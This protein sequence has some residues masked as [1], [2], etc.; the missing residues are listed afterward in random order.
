LFHD[1]EKS[2]N[3]GKTTKPFPTEYNIEGRDT[4]LLVEQIGLRNG[5]RKKKSQIDLVTVAGTRPEIIKLAELVPLLNRR[6]NHALLYT[7]QHFSENMKDIFF[8]ELHMAPDYE[9]RS[10]TSDIGSLKD[11]LVKCLGELRPRYVIVYGDTNSSMAAALAAEQIGSNLIHIEAGVR[12]FDLAVPEESIRIYI[13]SKA[14]YLFSPSQF[15]STV[16]AY[17][18]VRGQVH[19]TGNLIVD[20]CKKLYEVAMTKYNYINSGNG[21]GGRKRGPIEAENK[22]GKE[23]KGIIGEEIVRYPIPDVDDEFLLLTIHRP[24]NSDNPAKLKML[25]K[26]LEEVNYKVIFP[27]HPRTKQNLSRY[28]LQL[29]S[30]VQTIDAVGYLEFLQLIGKSK[31]ILTDSG[32]LQEEAVVLKKPCIT[33]RHTS[34]RWETILLNANI[35]FP[36]DRTESLDE[37]VEK[38]IHTKVTRNPYGENV[39][40]KVLD[41]MERSITL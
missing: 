32:G 17:E 9:L 2:G 40:Q 12:D 25:K 22:K 30:N 18:E 33:L 35:L 11:N 37:V 1:N 4:N 5:E 34:A 31:L 23:N 15:C 14:D 20:V 28:N 26:H 27:I 29:P 41:S 13:D 36:L 6:Y 7:G 39:A 24:E 10:N 8:D 19:T 16:L 3:D 38:M 21:N